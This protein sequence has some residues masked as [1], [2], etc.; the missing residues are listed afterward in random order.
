MITRNKSQHAL[1]V[2]STIAVVL[3]QLLPSRARGS[4]LQ[5]SPASDKEIIPLMI[6]FVPML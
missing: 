6:C 4:S 2:L 3:S 1:E 5:R